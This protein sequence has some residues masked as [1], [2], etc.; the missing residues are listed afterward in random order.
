MRM[1]LHETLLRTLLCEDVTA[2]LR[3]QN[4]KAS[5][6]L[7]FSFSCQAGVGAIRGCG[8]CWCEDA[9]V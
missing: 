1:L 4:P 2:R 9:A 5:L 7:G 3:V 6:M 8:R